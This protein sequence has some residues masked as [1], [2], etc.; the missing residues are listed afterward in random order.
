MLKRSLV[1]GALVFGMSLFFA[2]A[3]KASATNLDPTNLQMNTPGGTGSDPIVIGPTSVLDIYDV[4]NNTI[5]PDTLLLLLAVPT[6]E[7]APGAITSPT[8]TS[9][10][11]T[12]FISGDIYTAAGLTNGSVNNSPN[13][14][15]LQT[16]ESTYNGLSVSSFDLY[17]E[18]LDTTL[19]SKGTVTVNFASDLPLG[20]VAVAYGCY[21][22]DTLGTGTDFSGGCFD[23]TTNPPS[24]DSPEATAW[25]NADLTT[26]VPEPAT[27]TLLGAGLLAFIALAESRRRK[28][29]A[30]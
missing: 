1:V 16:A 22:G 2:G 27:I 23:T 4:G 11:S 9:S 21:G 7:S 19:A 8:V 14:M 13:F 26:K 30:W 25:T 3:Q 24:A 17:V 20:T 10:Y 12:T 29:L 6:G 18:Q 28:V 5:T 15:N